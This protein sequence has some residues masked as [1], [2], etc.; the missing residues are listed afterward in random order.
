MRILLTPTQRRD[1]RLRE[2][3]ILR[4]ADVAQS[5]AELT[6]YLACEHQPVEVAV[7]AEIAVEQQVSARELDGGAPWAA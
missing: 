1:L 5:C 3:A 4:R 6:L 2:K 7:L